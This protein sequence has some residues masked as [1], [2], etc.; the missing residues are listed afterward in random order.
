[1]KEARS[2]GGSA[3]GAVAV[4]RPSGRET[5]RGE[6]ARGTSHAADVSA[7]GDSVTGVVAAGTSNQ[8][9]AEGLT[10]HARLLACSGCRVGHSAA[11]RLGLGGRRLQATRRDA[12]AAAGQRACGGRRRCSGLRGVG[13]SPVGSGCGRVGPSAVD[14]SRLGGGADA[15]AWCRCA[16]CRGGRWAV[17]GGRVHPCVPAAAALDLL[18]AAAAGRLVRVAKM[19]GWR[20]RALPRWAGG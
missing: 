13:P 1:V 9:R 11:V 4:L 14:A 7:A 19:R 6:T 17:G 18:G 20:L 2:P 15:H 16:A 5:A 12:G 8:T 10:A 3:R